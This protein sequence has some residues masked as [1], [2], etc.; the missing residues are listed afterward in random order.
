MHTDNSRSGLAR[1]RGRERESVISALAEIR[2][3]QYG[4]NQHND[5]GFWILDF[6]LAM[7]E[8]RLLR[9]NFHFN[10]KSKI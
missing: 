3:Q 10:P 8:L 4:A 6:G 9:M 2:R 7:T 5:F 1:K